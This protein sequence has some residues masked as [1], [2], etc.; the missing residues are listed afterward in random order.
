MTDPS[1]EGSPQD[2]VAIFFHKPVR[3]GTPEAQAE[4]CLCRFEVNMNAAFLAA[5]RGL[6]GTFLVI[7]KQCPVHE[8]IGRLADDGTGGE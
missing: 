1:P 3:P 7:N 6:D 5:D 8:I 4:G 2:E